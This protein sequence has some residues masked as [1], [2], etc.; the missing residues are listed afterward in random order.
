M[1]RKKERLQ[2]HLSTS[3]PR[4]TLRPLKIQTEKKKKEEIMLNLNEARQMM[5]KIKNEVDNHLSHASHL[6]IKI[7]RILEL[8]KDE[9]ITIKEYK[10]LMASLQ[11]SI[12]PEEATGKKKNKVNQ[13]KEKNL[14]RYKNQKKVEIPD[15]EKELEMIDTINQLIKTNNNSSIHQKDQP[16]KLTSLN[17]NNNKISISQSNRIPKILI[18]EDDPTVIKLIG[19]FLIKENYSVLFAF[20]GEEGLVKA[21]KERPDLILLDI[22][23]PVIDGFQFLEISKND[24]DL[25]QI[26]IIIMSSLSQDADI[27]RALKKGASDYLTK[28]LSPQI[29]LAKIKKYLPSDS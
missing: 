9:L 12:N 26:P 16:T 10:R 17:K 25:A 29:L 1:L 27:L 11:K 13:K 2:D 14:S 4:N 22:M 15:L 18:I 24:K 3:I 8:L 19:Y 5:V 28:P 20:N 7:K 6:K 23:M 21:I